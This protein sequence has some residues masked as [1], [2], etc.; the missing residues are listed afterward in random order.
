MLLPLAAV[1]LS[2]L[3]PTTPA[4]TVALVVVIWVSLQERI[5]SAVGVPPGGVSVRLPLP[6]VAPNPLP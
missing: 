6:W 4:A 2:W 5:G 3:T 1:T